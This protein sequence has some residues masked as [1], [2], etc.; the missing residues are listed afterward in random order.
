[1]AEPTRINVG[2]LCDGIS[3][4]RWQAEAMRELA[5]VPGVS[6][7][8]LIVNDRP[9]AAQRTFM[10]RVLHFPWGMALYLRYRRQHFKVPAMEAVDMSAELAG[11]PRLNCRI[12]QRGHSQYFTPRDLEKIAALRCDVL[13]RFGFNILRGEVLD[14]PRFGVWS[15]HHG[16]EL[17]YRGGPAGFWELMKGDPIT[18]AILQRLT[19]RL[20]GGVVLRKG[21]FKTIDHSLRTSV[22]TVLRHSAIWP[23][24][25]C[26]ELL[27]GD[28]RSIDATPSDTRADVHRYPGNFTFLRF[29]WKQ[30][31]N[32]ARFH[33][34]EL[35]RHEEWNIGVLYQPIQS[36]LAERPSLNVRWLPSPGKGA[37]RADPFGFRDEAGEL[38]V[39]YE[40]YDYAKGVGEVGRIR[41]KRD[42]ILKRSRTLL[43]NGSHFSYPYVIEVEGVRYVVPEN[44]A[45]GRVD[46]YRFTADNDGL[47]F[48]RTL[49]DEPL[50]DPTLFQHNAP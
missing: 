16:D 47:E 12:D 21:W 50:Y 46:L 17:K 24:Q 39:V 41:P 8:A 36:L 29:L 45:S 9:P 32:K 30:A 3:F 7:S 1:M 5:K 13:L 4:Q 35:K 42:N 26:R 22:D 34:E 14:I 28:T 18:G 44:A 49:L 15:F 48:E 31:V 27:A 10:Q 20:D 23:A 38:N 37:F 33:R 19:D 40:K 43:N 25:V 6:V 11:V 2:V